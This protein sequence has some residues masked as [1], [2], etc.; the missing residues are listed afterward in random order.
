MNPITIPKGRRRLC[1]QKTAAPLPIRLDLHCRRDSFVWL[2]AFLILILSL[3]CSVQAQQV[4][5]GRLPGFENSTMSI[6]LSGPE[7]SHLKANPGEIRTFARNA[8]MQ[9]LLLTGLTESITGK[10][11]GVPVHQRLTQVYERDLKGLVREAGPGQSASMTYRV[12]FDELEQLAEAAKIS[13]KTIP[14]GEIPM[15]VMKIL[16]ELVNARR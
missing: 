15:Q 13:D 7:V 9:A 1:N 12:R 6:S 14:A 4:S 3:G 10:V 2:P 5:K 11:A 16:N 8:A